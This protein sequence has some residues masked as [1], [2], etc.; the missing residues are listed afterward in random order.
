MENKVLGETEMGSRKKAKNTAN[1]V[2]PLEVVRTCLR[3]LEAMCRTQDRGPGTD[4][5]SL[6]CAFASLN[7]NWPKIKR[8]TW[9]RLHAAYQ[10]LVGV[11]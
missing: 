5:Y 11:P 1:A 2:V 7:G 8:K 6:K 9:A 10:N 3:N 4:E